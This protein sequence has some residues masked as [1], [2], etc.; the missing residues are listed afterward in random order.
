[1]RR[2]VGVFAVGALLLSLA[3]ALFV[4]PWADGDPDGLDKVAEQEG[5][6]ATERKHDLGG[7]PVANYSVEGM[8]EGRLSTGIAGLTGVLVAFGLT[9]CVVAVL[10]FLRRRAD[11][12][13]A[14][15]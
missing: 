6:A 3:L 4:S 8:S 15:H 11:E 10:R 12:K 1:M 14:F 9:T 5:F 7:S 2:D 13:D